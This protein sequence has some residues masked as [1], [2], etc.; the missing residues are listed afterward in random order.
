MPFGRRKG[1]SV[2][3]KRIP[4]RHPKKKKKE[5]TRLPEKKKKIEGGPKGRGNEWWQS[6]EGGKEY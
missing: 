4:D 5:P 2:P 1:G 3:E 6:L